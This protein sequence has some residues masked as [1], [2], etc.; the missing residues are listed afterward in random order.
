VSFFRLTLDTP[1]WTSTDAVLM[2]TALIFV[3]RA[4]R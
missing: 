2:P 3:K 1:P 4:C